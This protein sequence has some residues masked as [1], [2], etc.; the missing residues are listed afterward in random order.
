MACNIPRGWGLN[1][2]SHPVLREHSALPLRGERVEYKVESEQHHPARHAAFGLLLAEHVKP[3][4]D[5]FRRV[6]KHQK[7]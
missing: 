2:P 3:E 1:T 4:L 6:L 5:A 7:K